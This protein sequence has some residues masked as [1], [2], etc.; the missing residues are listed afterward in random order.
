MDTRISTTNIALT[1]DEQTRLRTLNRRMARYF[2]K[3]LTL[4]W[5]FSG[6]S[7]ACTARCSVHSQSGYFRA[8]ATAGRAGAAMDL[9]FE[10]VVRQRRREHVKAVTG[11]A[12]AGA[13][14][15]RAIAR[16]PLREIRQ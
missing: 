3:M 5:G 9:A 8:H 12:R 13:N 7:K 16:A 4:S 6:S 15:K 2:R 1:P 10:K 14:R 11:R